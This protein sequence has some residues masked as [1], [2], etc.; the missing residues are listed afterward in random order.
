MKLDGIDIDGF[1]DGATAKQLYDERYSTV[2]PRCGVYI[3]LRESPR[4]PGIPANQQRRKIQGPRSV[5][6]L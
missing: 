2:P 1:A 3:V 4:A 5:V 6:S